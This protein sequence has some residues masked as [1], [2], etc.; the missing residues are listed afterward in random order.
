MARTTS[1]GMVSARLNLRALARR[2]L[3][4]TPTLGPY[5]PLRSNSILTR[6]IRGVTATADSGGGTG[7]RGRGCGG[8]AA[9]ATT[10]ASAC[11]VSRYVD[12][13]DDGRPPPLWGAAGGC[14][15]AASEEDDDGM[16]T[17]C[18]YG[19]Y[20]EHMQRARPTYTDY[21]HTQR[22]MTSVTLTLDPDRNDTDR[23]LASLDP[24]TLVELCRV[25]YAAS[26]L[27]ESHTNHERVSESRGMCALQTHIQELQNSVQQRDAT[28]KGMAL[29]LENTKKEM[30]RRLVT[31]SD[32]W[33]L[34]YDTRERAFSETMECMRTEFRSALSNEKTK[35]IETMA[36]TMRHLQTELD[37]L[38]N[39]SNEGKR[40]DG[41]R[42]IEG[43]LGSVIPTAHI[44]RC[45]SQGHSMDF[46]LRDLTTDT[47]V[48]VECKNKA[49]VQK[50]DLEKFWADRT[51]MRDTIT[52][53]VMVSMRS[54]IP[55]IG[56]LRVDTD[57]GVYTMYLG[58]NSPRDMAESL[59]HHIRVFWAICRTKPRNN[60]TAS[61]EELHRM[62]MLT[63]EMRWCTDGIRRCQRLTKSYAKSMEDEMRAMV[64]R[65]ESR[66]ECEPT[67]KRTRNGSCTKNAKKEETTTAAGTTGH[68]TV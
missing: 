36:N 33:K 22:E 8:V 19:A 67:H 5:L 55:G 14:I 53:C 11:R 9:T 64:T 13:D 7:D 47:V 12:D 4:V 15:H 52:G 3:L 27:A 66:I 62:E 60:D 10:W 21:K 41:E 24:H 48:A 61:A 59:A 46:L 50:V 40:L 16:Y 39:H 1:P 58:Y 51:T 42:T 34:R 43:I 45:A 54:Q 63:E 38:R 31:E 25:G 17:L 23:A 20:T 68:T 28:I 49:Q 57:Q 37:R 6:S 30:D 56:S 2:H 44:E 32:T 65:L 29:Q 35:E 26:A 18:V